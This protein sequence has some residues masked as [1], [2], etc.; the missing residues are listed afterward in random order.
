MYSIL[1]VDDEKNCRQIL[2][3]IIRKSGVPVDMIVECR[4]GA[5]ALEV[6]GSQGIDVMFTDI[7][8]P[9]IDGITL[10]KEKIGRAHV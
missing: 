3:N 9:G 8:M 7:C 5:E 2:K 6:L 1:I 4:D 10:V